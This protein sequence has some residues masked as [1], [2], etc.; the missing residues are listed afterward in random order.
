MKLEDF[1]AQEIQDTITEVLQ[2]N[3]YTVKAYARAL[4]RTEALL[5]HALKYCPNDV[6]EMIQNSYKL[7]LDNL[8]KL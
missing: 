4:G 8:K 1:A 7:E 2:K 6:V 5:Y 3:N